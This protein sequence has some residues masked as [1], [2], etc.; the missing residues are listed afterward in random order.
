MMQVAIQTSIAWQIQSISPSHHS[1]TQHYSVLSTDLGVGDW[2][3]ALLGLGVLSGERQEAG[4]TQRHPRRGALGRDPETD[5]A[6]HH[7]QHRGDVGGEEEV[8]GVPLQFEHGREAGE[9]AGG[10]VDGAVLSPEGLYLQLGQ[11]EGE[12]EAGKVTVTHLMSG[13][14]IRGSMMEAFKIQKI[15]FA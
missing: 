9:G 6:H 2:R 1:T 12:S 3:Q 14:T 8:A 13:L 10:V 7:D 4:H 15:S 5:P 11:S